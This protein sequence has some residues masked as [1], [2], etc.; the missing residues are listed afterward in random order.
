ME[1]EKA[2]HRT[3]RRAQATPGVSL[4][5]AM[6]GRPLGIMRKLADLFLR[7]R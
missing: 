4:P 7:L 1:D 5:M 2:T 6:Q 3:P